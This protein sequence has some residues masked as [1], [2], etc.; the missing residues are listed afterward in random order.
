MPG[1]QRL[2]TLSLLTD[3]AE[4]GAEHVGSVRA[5]TWGS[6]RKVTEVTEG[7]ADASIR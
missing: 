4:K 5:G 3:P 2:T 7:I 6:S 1:D